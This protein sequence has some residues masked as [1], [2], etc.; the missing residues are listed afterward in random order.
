MNSSM[1]RPR[2]T[3]HHSACSLNAR[4][5]CPCVVED[6]VRPGQ[7]ISSTKFERRGGGKGANQAVSVARAGGA[8]SLVGAV[9]E[10]GAWL[11]RD[12]EGYGVSTADISLVQVCLSPGMDRPVT[13][14][15]IPSRPSD[16]DFA[17]IDV[18]G[19]WP[20]HHSTYPGR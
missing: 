1:V 2:R 9:G 18:G 7:T 10:D 12:L 15:Y 17:S 6:F 19:H 8:V 11:M 5:G 20:R 4:N 14:A 13:L 3:V 16:A